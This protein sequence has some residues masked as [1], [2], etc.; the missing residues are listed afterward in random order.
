MR[1]QLK[2]SRFN[3]FCTDETGDLLVFNTF[4]VKECRIPRR[5]AQEAVRLLRGETEAPD[6]LH[7]DF[8]KY[9][10]FVEES[11]DELA[12]YKAK[13]YEYYDS[14]RLD[15]SILP[16]H[17]CNCRCVYCY[18]DFQDGILSAAAQEKLVRF[19]KDKLQTCSSLH[20]GWFGGEPLAGMDV[21]RNLSQQFMALCKDLHKPYSASI[22]TNGT[23]LTYE[24]FTE[25]QK[26]RV[27]TYQ[28]TIDGTKSV[29]DMQRPLAGGG[30]S[31]DMVMRNLTEIKR[32]KRSKSF[33]IILRINLTRQCMAQVR[34]YLRTLNSL[35]GGDS[36]FP[37]S[38][39]VAGDWGGD[40]IDQFRENLI[41]SADELDQVREQLYQIVREENLS[42]NVNGV[43]GRYSEF[44][45]F[46]FGCYANKKNFYTI[47]STG[48][49]RKCAQEIRQGFP[50]IG[51]LETYRDLSDIRT[52]QARWDSVIF[53]EYPEKC[54][55][56]CFLPLGCWGVA[57]C[58]LTKFASKYASLFPR[59]ELP[60][61]PEHPDPGG[62]DMED[63]CCTDVKRDPAMFL[64]QVAKEM[65]LPVIE[66]IFSDGEEKV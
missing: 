10:F 8:I 49:I 56:C 13:C 63:P 55:D 50:P 14:P 52:E 48:L 40:R 18:E 62:G 64:R 9:G 57:V 28:I 2:P 38:I 32:L 11:T 59:A 43:G 5:H 31:Y 54:R 33:Y 65:P 39:N 34:E 45:G 60:V 47:D 23:L 46:N 29:H 37:L 27:L 24:T 4:T 15:L 19:V 22:T 35:F 44:L 25:L 58:P 21:I 1:V 66:E 17:R 53:P 51:D 7:G 30:S 16:T 61:C 26:Y 42:L 36:R 12:A 3:C 41:Q 6:N 20:V